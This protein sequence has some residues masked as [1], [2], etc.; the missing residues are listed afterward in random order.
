[1]PIH[2]PVKYQDTPTTIPVKSYASDGSGYTVIG[3]MTLF[4]KK[5]YDNMSYAEKLRYDFYQGQ[6]NRKR[7]S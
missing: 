7:E 3:G 6:L 1:M 2:I 5:L 4:A